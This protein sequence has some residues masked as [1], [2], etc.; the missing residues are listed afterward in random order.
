M[1]GNSR[2]AKSSKSCKSLFSASVFPL[3]S[4]QAN[5]GNPKE[6]VYSLMPKNT[7]APPLPFG[8]FLDCRKK[9]QPTRGRPSSH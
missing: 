9:G 8:M 1:Q 4:S 7:K 5:P 6:S 2:Y 3:L